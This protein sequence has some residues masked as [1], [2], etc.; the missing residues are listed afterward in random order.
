MNIAENKPSWKVLLLGG[1]SGVGKSSVS[2]A[3]ART[4]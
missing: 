1:A 4:E 2:Y 3:L